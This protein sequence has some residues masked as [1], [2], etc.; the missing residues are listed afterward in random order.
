MDI[1]F[2]ADRHGRE[3]ALADDRKTKLPPLPF[4]HRKK[5]GVLRRV[6]NRD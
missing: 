1:D 2:S 3:N 5:T 4:R 6:V